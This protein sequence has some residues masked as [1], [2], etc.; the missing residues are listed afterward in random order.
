MIQLNEMRW[1][2]LV[3]GIMVTSACGARSGVDALEW[4]YDAQ[5]GA[6]VTAGGRD[7]AATNHGGTG[8]Q[9]G[10]TA[11]GGSTTTSGGMTSGGGTTITDSCV[12]FSLNSIDDV[13]D[14]RI[15]K[16]IAPGLALNWWP[17]YE[18]GAAIQIGSEKLSPPRG[19][20]HVAMHARTDG[21]SLGLGFELSPCAHIG[22]PRAVAFWARA[23]GPMSARVLISS[24]TNTLASAGGWC[25]STL[26]TPAHDSV[27]LS[28]EW[29]HFELPLSSFVLQPPGGLEAFRSLEISLIEKRGPLELWIDD[30]EF[31]R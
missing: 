1:V 2:C 19:S 10:S 23:S 7:G 18:P 14:G 16:W 21:P 27:R 17:R 30:V 9:G 6:P 3:L 13:E 15:D 11:T 4:G 26:C 31:L 24:Q 29:R 25:Y 5:A 8:A 22:Y 28:P 20:S 12:P